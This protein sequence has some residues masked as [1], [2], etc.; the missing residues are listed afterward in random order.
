MQEGQI[1]GGY[2]LLARKLFDS[3]LMDK[4]PLW[5]KLWVWM[6]GQANWKDRDKLKKGQFVATISDMQDA[7]SYHIG[8][9]KKAPTKDEIRNAYEAFAKATMITTTKTTRGSVVTICN[10]DKYQ[11][12]KTYEAHSE[13]HCEDA[14]KT[15]PTP[16]DTESIRKQEN[17]KHKTK[18]FKPPSVEDVFDYCHERGNGIDAKVFVDHYISNGWMVGRNKMKDWKATVRTWE[19]RRKSVKSNMQRKPTMQTDMDE[20]DALLG[21]GNGKQGMGQADGGF[22][23]QGSKVIELTRNTGG[24]YG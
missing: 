5:M 6:V 13:A 3:W 23:A 8:Y 12:F 14:T 2:I 24:N 9:R 10:Y 16:H 19:G 20:L 21:G 18:P 17:K 1:Q 11:D 4:P 22:N 7:M 15:E